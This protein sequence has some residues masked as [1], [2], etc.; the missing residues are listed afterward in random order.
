MPLLAFRTTASKTAFNP[1]LELDESFCLPPDCDSK[2]ESSVKAWQQQENCDGY[3]D[4]AVSMTCDYGI[5]TGFIVAAIVV[6][7][8]V[9]ALCVAAV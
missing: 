1:A 9:F 4:C 7:L 3:A 6:T 5:G 8:G 2:L